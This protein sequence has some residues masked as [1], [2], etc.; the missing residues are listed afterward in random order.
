MKNPVNQRCRFCERKLSLFKRL[1][2]AE[3][4][5]NSH[6]WAYIRQ[7]NELALQRLYAYG[8]PSAES[9]KPALAQSFERKATRKGQPTRPVAGRRAPVPA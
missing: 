9:A 6:H 1:L 2:K 3:F 8:S 5:N 4:C 7:Q